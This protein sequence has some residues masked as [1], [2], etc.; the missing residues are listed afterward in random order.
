MAV[1]ECAPVSAARAQVLRDVLDPDD[2]PA[3]STRLP[4][5]AVTAN[6]IEF[7]TVWNGGEGLS[8]YQTRAGHAGEPA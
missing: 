3:P 5:R 2:R 1:R 8:S 7:E 4:S 6:G